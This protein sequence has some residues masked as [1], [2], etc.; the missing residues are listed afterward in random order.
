MSPFGVTQK[1]VTI[2]CINKNLKPIMDSYIYNF[3]FMQDDIPLFIVGAQSRVFQPLEE[4]MEVHMI[5]NKVIL[6]KRRSKC[7]DF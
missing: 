7:I 2:L 3:I 1:L 4:R 5:V 6:K